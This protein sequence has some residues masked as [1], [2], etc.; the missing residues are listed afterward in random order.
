MQNG[1]GTGF[2]A[3]VGRSDSV[4]GATRIA[5]IVISTIT[6]LAF[7]AAGYLLLH[8]I[9]A[10]DT[11]LHDVVSQ[12]SILAEKEVA[13]A[14]RVEA[15]EASGAVRITESDKIYDRIDAHLAAI[16]KTIGDLSLA[17]NTVATEL[18]IRDHQ[19]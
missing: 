1:N 18:K 17:I 16:D 4:A 13:L 8:I 6:P 11:R 15:I 9:Q 3:R 14:S 7:G 5:T 10:L 2:V 19:P 12:E